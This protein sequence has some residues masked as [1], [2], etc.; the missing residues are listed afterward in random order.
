[1][2]RGSGRVL[3]LAIEGLETRAM[4]AGDSPVIPNAAPPAIAYPAAERTDQVD[5]YFGTPVADPYRWLED[6]ADPR[7]QAWVEAQS[8]LAADTLQALP[9]RADRAAQMSGLLR[10]PSV[11][12]PV[13]AGRFLFWTE[14]DGGQAQSVL[15]VSPAGRHAGR[16]LL[17]PNTLS[18]DGTVS[19]AAWSP[20]P[21][22]HHVAWAASDGGS[23]W[24]TWRIR[25]VRSGRDLPE[26]IEWSKFTDVA[27]TNDG[28]GFFY[29]RYPEP[30]DP[31]E[32]SNQNMTIHYHRLG[33][34]VSRD[35]QVF[36]APD[37][38]SLYVSQLALPGHARVWLSLS[39]SDE[40][41]TLASVSLTAA[42]PRV[43]HLPTVQQAVYRVV[44]HG[45]HHAWIYTT[46]DAPN[47]R[48]VRVDL[49][50]PE[51]ANWKEVIAERTKSIDQVTQV[52]SRLVVEYLH[53]ATSRLEVLTHAGRP[54]GSVDLPGLG[55]VT[56]VTAR[57]ASRWAFVSYTDY[58]QPPAVL[59]LDALSL[60]TRP[61]YTPT[62]P[63]D[64]ADFVTEQVF[65]RSRDGTRVPA[66]VSHLRSVTPTGDAPTWLYGYGGFDVSLTP[67]YSPDAIAWMQGGGV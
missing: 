32:S 12:A 43:W 66:F 27:W 38:P 58:T 22:G 61:W 24:R 57:N 6:P 35:V 49:R 10:Q 19:L 52:G 11:Q 55:S 2:P 59:S 33:T 60:R 36:D 39:T 40:T 5:T 13:T 29:S 1:M 67:T 4:F 21:T 3:S 7:T 17:D 20:S 23:D 64:P 65:A 25:D 18:A 63:F 51:P 9:T 54:I 44:A 45:R 48:V 26:R 14:T 30:T 62:V 41:N 31:L 37:Q 8:Q 16:I 15:F 42:G 56:A 28:R 50:R 47:G 53:D 46:A 34:A